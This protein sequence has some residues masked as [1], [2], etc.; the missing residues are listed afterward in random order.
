MAVPGLR[1]LLLLWLP[2]CVFVFSHSVLRA[3]GSC[4]LTDSRN[5][6]LTQLKH[7][8]TCFQSSILR[9]VFL[10]HTLII[11]TP[12]KSLFNHLSWTQHDP[13]KDTRIHCCD[14]VASPLPNL[15]LTPSLPL[16][17]QTNS[18]LSAIKAQRISILST[19]FAFV[20]VSE[21]V[22]APYLLFRPLLVCGLWPFLITGR[23]CGIPKSSL[24]KIHSPTL[25]Y[26]HKHAHTYSG[27]DGAPFYKAVNQKP[28]QYD[29]SVACCTTLTW[30]K[31][32]THRTPLGFFNIFIATSNTQEW[33]FKY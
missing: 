7:S 32:V 13:F 30:L 22:C 24:L 26:T 5:K 28:R 4:L 2:H 21:S 20:C 14:D 12:C 19:A 15:N 31:Q 17:A 25:T 33:N 6:F 11:L 27:Y 23:G 8:H 1:H 16:S 29:W 18:F 3:W 9:S 10:H